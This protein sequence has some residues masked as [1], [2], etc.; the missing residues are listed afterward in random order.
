MKIKFGCWQFFVLSLSACKSTHYQ[1]AQFNLIK[2][3]IITGEIKDNA[4]YVNFIKPY[5]ER[6]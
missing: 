6:T 4:D 2:I 3:P 5:K 1:V